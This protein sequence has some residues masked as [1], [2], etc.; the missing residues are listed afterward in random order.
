MLFILSMNF[1]KAQMSINRVDVKWTTYSEHRQYGVQYMAIK[2]A[3]MPSTTDT[4]FELVLTNLK[5]PNL[6]KPASFMFKGKMADL[7]NLY[8]AMKSFFLEEN[9]RKQ[10]YNMTIDLGENQLFFY[11]TRQ[12]GTTI[13]LVTYPLGY[14]HF[15]ERSVDKLFNK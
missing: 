13:L 15:T 4:T 6:Q 14:T 2:Y 11:N 12:M 1:T 3:T 8:S 10:D 5:Y 7:E 9:K